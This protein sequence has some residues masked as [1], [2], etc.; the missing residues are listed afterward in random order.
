MIK[1]FLT[2]SLFMIC[3]MTFGQ[4]KTEMELKVIAEKLRN[5]S[6]NTYV[7]T[8]EPTVEDLQGIFLSAKDVGD[9]WMHATDFYIAVEDNYKPG[10]DQTEVIVKG[11]IG[12]DLRYAKEHGLPDEYLI[13]KEKIKNT[14]EIYFIEYVKK[15]EKSGFPLHTFVKTRNHWVYIPNLW[16][17]F[18]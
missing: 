10:D 17:I 18:E 1:T 6:T 16:Q 7:K 3:S 12:A 8:L 11:A 15:G 4:T 9:A 14:V 2:L 13:I 5:D